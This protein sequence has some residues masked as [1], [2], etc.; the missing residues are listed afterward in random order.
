MRPDE[1]YQLL[2]SLTSPVVA[3]TS[4]RAGKRNGMIS[5][6]AV[7]ASLVPERDGDDGG[8]L[9][10]EHAARVAGGVRDPARSGAAVR[11]RAVPRHQASLSRS[12]ACSIGSCGCAVTHTPGCGIVTLKAS[13][14]RGGRAV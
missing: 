9:P 1:T 3:I 13:F 2:R 4:E 8:A 12:A 5:D 6:S 7:R 11:R 14:R 10:D